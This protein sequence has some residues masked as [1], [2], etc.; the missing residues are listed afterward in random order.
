MVERDPYPK[1]RAQQA[2]Y[3]EARAM[4]IEWGFWFL[5][6]WTIWSGISHVRRDSEPVIVIPPPKSPPVGAT[7][8][9]V[10]VKARRTSLPGLYGCEGKS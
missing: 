2:R 8:F 9:K 10:T 5:I 7:T 1:R 6:G 4:I 3:R